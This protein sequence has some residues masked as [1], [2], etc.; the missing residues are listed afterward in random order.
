MPK[1]GPEQ[2][3]RIVPKGFERGAA[4]GKNAELTTVSFN[5]SIALQHPVLAP[6]SAGLFDGESK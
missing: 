5:D 3:E 1:L 6:A 2:S 4:L